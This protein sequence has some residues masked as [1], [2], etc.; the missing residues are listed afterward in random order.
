MPFQQFPEFN[1]P[2]FQEVLRS[3]QLTPHPDVAELL[4]L[5]S[6]E[7]SKLIHLANL[8]LQ[9]QQKKPGRNGSSTSA[10]LFSS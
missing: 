8:N 7:D 1:Q 9:A 5:G 4:L 10:Q 2:H 6:H 3:L